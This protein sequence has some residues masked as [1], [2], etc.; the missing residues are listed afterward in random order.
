MGH[1]HWQAHDLPMGFPF[2]VRETGLNFGLHR[3]YVAPWQCHKLKAL[4]SISRF[5]VGAHSVR[6]A[7]LF[8]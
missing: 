8:T 6:P 5:S 7:T 1:T 2:P 4:R 3:E